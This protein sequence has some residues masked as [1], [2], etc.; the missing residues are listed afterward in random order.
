MG[1]LQIYCSV[2]LPYMKTCTKCSE[3]K[4]ESDYF[5]RDKSTGRLH[6]QCKVCY[7]EHR[8]SYSAKHYREYGDAYRERAKLRR[9]RIRRALQNQLIDYMKDKSCSVCNEADIRVLEFDHLDRRT[10]FF[11]IARAIT[12]GLEWSKILDEMEKCQ[13][14]CANCHKKRTSV[15]FNWFKSRG[16]E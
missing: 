16:I 12:D 5:V 3:I 8:K 2:R 10:K 9:A 7:K 6:A 11:S 13:V 14:L 1:C 15:Q 4:L